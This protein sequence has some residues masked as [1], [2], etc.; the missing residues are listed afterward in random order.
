MDLRERIVEAYGR[1]EGTREEVAKRFKVSL[2][3]VKKSCV[4]QVQQK[5]IGGMMAW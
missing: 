5:W 1:K 2:G 3:M 4:R